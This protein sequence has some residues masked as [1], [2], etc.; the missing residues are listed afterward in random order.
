MR[1]DGTL[2]TTDSED[3]QDEDEPMT[4]G[5]MTNSGTTNS[6]NNLKIYYSSHQHQSSTKKP[7]VME[8][9]DF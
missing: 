2:A 6:N 9:I 5:K 1:I 3:N 7:F 4:M 8:V